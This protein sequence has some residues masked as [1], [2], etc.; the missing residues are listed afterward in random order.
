MA[1]VSSA[2]RREADVRKGTTSLVRCLQYLMTN[3][4]SFTWE[5]FFSQYLESPIEVERSECARAAFRT[6]AP[7]TGK[8]VEK[9]VVRASIKRIRD[10]SAPVKKY[11]DEVIAHR[12][13]SMSLSTQMLT[14][15]QIDHAL[16]ELTEVTKLYYGLR[17]PGST[18][19]SV[20]PFLSP[21]W[22]LVFQEPWFPKG[23]VLP[24]LPEHP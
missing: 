15:S 1:T 4:Q 24:S 6:Y 2:I 23:S 20:T 11:A 13:K 17:H 14:M 19:G 3:S 10:A 7:M 22:Q 9:A 16:D 21:T 8:C 5:Y 12:G 18:L